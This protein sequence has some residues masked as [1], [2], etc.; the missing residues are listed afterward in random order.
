MASPAVTPSIEPSATYHSEIRTGADGLR[1]FT[2]ICEIDRTKILCPAFGIAPHR[3]EGT[4]EG[5]ANPY[6]A[7][8]IFY[9]DCYTFIR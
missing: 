6:F 2:V 3:V 9:G 1:T 5:Q 8:G 7:A 4:L